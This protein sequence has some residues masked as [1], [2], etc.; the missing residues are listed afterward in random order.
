MGVDMDTHM[1]DNTLFQPFRKMMYYY[2]PLFIIVLS[3]V[4]ASRMKQNKNTFL[5]FVYQTLIGFAVA[6]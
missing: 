6:E 3:I 1:E 2:M 5:S 4:L